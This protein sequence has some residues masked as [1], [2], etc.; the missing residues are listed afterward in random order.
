MRHEWPGRNCSSTQRPDGG[1]AD[2]DTLPS[3]PYATGEA[4]VALHDAGM[5]AGDAAYQRGVQ[6]LLKTQL[7]DGSWYAK[8][9][10]LP[11]Q[12]YFDVGFPHGVDQWISACATSW[13]TMALALASGS[14]PSSPTTAAALR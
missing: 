12:P 1:W 8:T 3:G 10:S 6:Y 2:V 9:R 4:L 13:S 5:A 14:A 7:T 11:V